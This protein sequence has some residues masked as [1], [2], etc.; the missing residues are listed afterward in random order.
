MRAMRLARDW[1]GH[2]ANE[3]NRRRLA[4]VEFAE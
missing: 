4:A 3:V 2:A 1:I